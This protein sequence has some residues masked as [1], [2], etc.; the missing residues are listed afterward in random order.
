M[1]QSFVIFVTSFFK[2]AAHGA[3]TITRLTAAA[4]IA[5]AGLVQENLEDAKLDLEKIAAL[6]TKLDALIGI[7]QATK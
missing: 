5:A 7:K 1:W 6:D 4:N 2:G 3:Q